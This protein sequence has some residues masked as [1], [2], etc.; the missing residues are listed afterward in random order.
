MHDGQKE[1]AEKEERM[2]EEGAEGGDEEEDEEEKLWESIGWAA[3]EMYLTPL[4][5]TVNG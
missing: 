2:E 4:S 1:R 3:R 5:C